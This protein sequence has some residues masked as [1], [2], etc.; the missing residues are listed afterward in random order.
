[1]L[2]YKFECVWA[3][4]LI[5]FFSCWVHSYAR[6]APV[7][8]TKSMSVCPSVHIQTMTEEMLS[9]FNDIWLENVSNCCV[10]TV[11]I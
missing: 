1:V 9:K 6:G 8:N 7:S 3:V 4:R 10:M 2:F 11:V 5:F